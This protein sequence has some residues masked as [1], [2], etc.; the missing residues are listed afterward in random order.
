M[1]RYVIHPGATTELVVL[2]VVLAA[3]WLANFHFHWFK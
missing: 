3:I 2:E 1:L